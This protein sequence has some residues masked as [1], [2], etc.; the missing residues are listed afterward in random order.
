LTIQVREI[1]FQLLRSEHQEKS[2]AKKSAGIDGFS[3]EKMGAGW[4][5]CPQCEGYVKGPL[6]KECPSC[7]HKF[8][9]KSRVVAKPDAAAATRAN[10]LE[11][12][13]MLLA[14]KMGGLPAVTKAFE[15]LK[16]DPLMA[17]TIRCGGVENTSRLVAAIE[18]KLKD[19]QV[20]S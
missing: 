19:V 3:T 15:K 7:H 5:R 20:G 13:V 2:M 17:F 16:S 10:E 4:K 14:L 9:F 12:H 11:E 18:G 1:R 6:S 8:E